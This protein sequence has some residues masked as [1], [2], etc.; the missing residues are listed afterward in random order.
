V[1]HFIKGNI[2]DRFYTD[3]PL[4]SKV[5]IYDKSKWDK[6]ILPFNFYSKEEVYKDLEK[7]YSLEEQFMNNGK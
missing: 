2:V 7:Q 6:P 1:S 5:Y 4:Q 3:S